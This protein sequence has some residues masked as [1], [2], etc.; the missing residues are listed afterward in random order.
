MF[1]SREYEF[2]DL[3][4]LLGGVDITGFRGIQYTESMEKSAVYGK[5]RYPRSIQRGN[6]TI[7]G[8]ITL[9]Q[10]EL[11]KLIQASPRRSVLNIA[12]DATIC[13]GGN[14]E[15]GAGT[16]IADRI[17]GLQFTESPKEL[18][19]GDQFMEVTL[20]FIALRVLNNV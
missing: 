4:L 13:Y 6:Y 10:S 12:L 8:E 19:Q 5:G 16:I 3:A 14:M 9:L 18:N 11:N 1:N 15:E 7:E 2:A 17:V 20:P